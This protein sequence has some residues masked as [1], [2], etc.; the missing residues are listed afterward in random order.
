VAPRTTTSSS[1]TVS[2]SVSRTPLPPGWRWT[3]RQPDASAPRSISRAGETE[4]RVVV[5]GAGAVGLCSAYYLAGAGAGVTVLDER[6][7]GGGASRHNAGW[8]VPSMSG[9][10]PA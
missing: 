2:G 10:V 1:T 3:G 4:M 6:D 7:V 8:V 5:I 9:P